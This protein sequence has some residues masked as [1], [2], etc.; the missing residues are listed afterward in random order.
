MM[1]LLLMWLETLPWSLPLVMGLK[2]E[3][4]FMPC[5][6]CDN[7]EEQSLDAHGGDALRNT[8]EVEW[9]LGIWVGGAE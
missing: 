7:T 2:W 4:L 5:T 9:K 3:V 1:L 6:A 8:A